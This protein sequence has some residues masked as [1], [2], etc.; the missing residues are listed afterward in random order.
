MPVQSVHRALSIIEYLGAH[1][2]GAGLLDIA[3]DLSLPKSTCHRLLQTLINKNFVHQDINTE[4]YIL[5]MKIANISSNMID[6]IDV[7][8][9]ARP[10][11]EK[12]SKDINE[13][14]H[15]CVRE[16]NY[17][18]Y[19]DKVESTRSLRMYSQIG[20]TAM[21]HC[22]G[23]GKMMIADLPEE[24][25]IQL[26]SKEGLV[27]FTE[28][29]FTTIDDFLQEMRCIRQNGYSLDR[30]E[31][32]TGIYCIA[33][34]IKDY[35]NKTIAAFSISGPIERIKPAIEEGEY[36]NKILTTSKGISERLGYKF[37]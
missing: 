25:I 15:L 24:E 29:T 32:E 27:K 9:V 6:S 26:V 2:K 33:A 7:R 1:P 10:F 36:K 20:K 22:T 16:N 30:E 23:V 8:H 5:S 31:H 19:I 3:K 35:T 28:N 12:L 34:P 11:I 4:H 13:V 37:S 21:L 18:V 17:V 14:V